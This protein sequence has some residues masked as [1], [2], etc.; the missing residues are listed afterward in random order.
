MKCDC[1]SKLKKNVG[2]CF[3]N[4]LIAVQLIIEYIYIMHSFSDFLLSFN[5]AFSQ[6]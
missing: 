5:A 6:Q 2:Q 4:P 3:S 1:V